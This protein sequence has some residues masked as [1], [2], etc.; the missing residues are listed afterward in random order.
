MG[1]EYLEISENTIEVSNKFYYDV[2]EK[3]MACS[4]WVSER[5]LERPH[6]FIYF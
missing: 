5:V 1:L 2:W 6:L 4:I 3:E